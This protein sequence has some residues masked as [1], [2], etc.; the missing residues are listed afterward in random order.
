MTF[1]DIMDKVRARYGRMQID[2]RAQ[3][4]ERMT[5]RLQSTETFDTHLSNLTE[6]YAI[7]EIGS[8][9]IAQDKQVKISRF[10]LLGQACMKRQDLTATG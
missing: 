4:D 10:Y 5:T 8:Y 3:L 2:T 6:N 7:S 1:M 9:P